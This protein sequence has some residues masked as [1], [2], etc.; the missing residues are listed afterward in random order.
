MPQ[1]YRIV[2]TN[3]P[4]VSDFLSAQELGRP[5]PTRIELLPYFAGISVYATEAGAR[6]QAHRWWPR[7]GTFLAQLEVPEG[8]DIQHEKSMTDPN[9][10]TLWASPDVLL[11]L[12]TSVREIAPPTP[13]G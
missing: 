9:H 2:K 1:F 12:V 11:A 10:H 5:R 7:L 8:G 6:S 4:T 3:P 13:V